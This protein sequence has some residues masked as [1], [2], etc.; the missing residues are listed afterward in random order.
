MVV[1]VCVV[2]EVW[3]YWIGNL[4]NTLHYSN[5]S[6]NCKTKNDCQI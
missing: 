1:M 5:K 6:R 3:F 2:M 4:D